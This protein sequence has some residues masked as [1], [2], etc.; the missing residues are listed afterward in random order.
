MN[1]NFG[2]AFRR[3]A[4]LGRK[5]YHLIQPSASRQGCNLLAIK[6]A[7]L[8][9]CGEV[10]CDLNILSTSFKQAA[11]PSLNDAKVFIVTIVQALLF[12]VFPHP[13][14]QVQVW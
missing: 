12:D 11:M 5:R 7:F 10:I 14:D 3:D 1:R 2:F 9:E 13:F 8:A 6:D 4:S